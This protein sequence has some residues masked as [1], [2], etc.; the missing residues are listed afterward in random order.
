[1]AKE[2]TKVLFIRIPE[3]MM[4]QFDNVAEKEGRTKNSLGKKMIKEFLERQKN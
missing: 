4:K 3:S 1:M 2:K